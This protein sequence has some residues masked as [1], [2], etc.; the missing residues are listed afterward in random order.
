MKKQIVFAIP[1]ILT[2]I[3]ISVCLKLFVIGEPIDG[4]QMYWTA[5]VEGQTMELHINT[6][7]SAAAFRGWRLKRDGGALFISARK[8]L[9][10]SLFSDGFYDATIDLDGVT[11]IYLGGRRIWEEAES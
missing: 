11:D 5:S 8:V 3:A 10:S 7:E 9:V 4:E 6:V 2:V 1:A